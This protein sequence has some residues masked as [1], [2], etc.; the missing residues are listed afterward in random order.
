MAFCGQV[1]DLSAIV[2]CAPSNAVHEVKLAGST[3]DAIDLASKVL[4]P[5]QLQSL[6]ASN[7]IK[8]YSS[9]YSRLTTTT[10]NITT[11]SAK[12]DIEAL[13]AVSLLIT[14]INTM[15]R[16]QGQ[17]CYV[18]IASME[19]VNLVLFGVSRAV[20]GFMDDNDALGFKKERFRGISVK[21]Q[22]GFTLQYFNSHSFTV[23]GRMSD[24]QA[25]RVIKEWDRRTAPYVAEGG[26]ISTWPKQAMLSMPWLRDFE[27]AMKKYQAFIKLRKDRGFE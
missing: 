10:G 1:L 6:Q 27:T 3:P 23:L 16:R 19:R 5:F 24:E 2:Y 26:R 15:L 4:L 18:Y 9:T 21:L 14:F 11:N 8:I 22:E 25:I 20:P 7:Q 17:T 12:T 13:H